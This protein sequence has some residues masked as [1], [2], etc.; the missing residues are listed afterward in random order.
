MIGRSEVGTGPAGED[1]L[2]RDGTIAR[3]RDAAPG[4]R[5]R[6][7]HLHEELSDRHRYERFFHVGDL[8]AARF[9]EG[10]L[11]RLAD[12]EAVA[13]VAVVDGHIAGLASC[14]RAA[15]DGEAELAVVVA[16]RYV[17]RGVATL[18]LEHLAVAASEAGVT[19]LVTYV[20]ADNA[21]AFDVLHHAGFELTSSPH[22][23]TVEVRFPVRLTE[24]VLA[25]MAAREQRADADSIGTLLRP[26]SVAVIGASRRESH[27]GHQVVRNLLRARF[28]GT[29]HPVNPH[30][31]YLLGMRCH[32]SILDVA[33][34][35]L[36]V[37][38]VP[39]AEVPKVV[40][41]CAQGGVRD[42]VILS[43]GFAEAGP[44]GQR[45]Q[46]EVLAIARGSGMRVVG[47]NCLGVA[48]T[49]PD[50]R[51][52]ATFSPMSAGRGRVAM[53]TQ[54]GAVGIAALQ[55]A[56][57]LGVGLSAFI[58]SGNKA[59][60][61]CNDLLMYA[62]E[63]HATDVV[64]LYLES[65]GNPRKFS[66]LAR[67]LGAHKPVVALVGGSSHA[68]R[69]GALGHT[70]SAVTSADAVDALF[71]QCGVIGVHG[72]EQLLQTTSVLANQ[73]LPGGRRVGIVSNAGGPGILAADACASEGL[74]LTT[75]S[76][77]TMAAIREIVPDA[78]SVQMP[79]DL[80]SDVGW[81]AYSE[82]VSTIARSGEIDMLIAL[83]TP[84]PG[85]SYASFTRALRTAL[86]AGSDED[87]PPV[88]TIAV[89][90]DPHGPSR[91]ISAGDHR[92]PVFSFPED[93]ARAL[94]PIARYAEWRAEP[95]TPVS[96][97]PAGSRA[98]AR[99]VV[100]RTLRVAPEGC[101]L[102]EPDA[103]QLLAAYGIGVL[104]SVLA[105]GAEEAVDAA[106]W[107]GYPV[108]VKVADPLAHRTDVGGVR[109]GLRSPDEVR[110][111]AHELLGIAA[112][113]PGLLVQRQVPAGVELI[114]GVT[115][116]KVFGP[117]VMVGYGGVYTELIE[118]RSFL[119]TP[120]CR[121]D[122]AAA[123]ADLRTAPLLTGYRGAPAADAA[124]V[125]HLLVCLGRLA[126]DLPEVAEID[127]NPVIVHERGVSVVDAKV[128]L[129]PAAQAPDPDLR[130]LRP[131]IGP[132]GSD[133]GT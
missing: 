26:R 43:S 66:R 3:V 117:L 61:S 84:L 29:V 70:A 56:E 72:L 120:L 17:H 62:A 15:G 97:A 77:E 90:L 28:T 23:E 55:R 63:D 4:D 33:P 67:R 87:A 65:F 22:R 102:P 6:L 48:N 112:E 9:V 96:E 95:H 52:D 32:S 80:G 47:P 125:E 105:D 41:E 36:A 86:R 24:R 2:L 110:L 53:M 103:R 81:E 18:L 34:V 51:L 119:L 37:L 106:E 107:V 14:T 74:R 31:D 132:G 122:A 133:V 104:P 27:P 11:P 5:D 92:V 64:A 30:C 113:R 130:R 16:D 19:D 111:A 54:S 118:D 25:A 114:A 7:V 35:D 98:T 68:G 21:A 91:P 89:M 8:D 75:L 83:R 129:H 93:A 1:V 115:Q 88:T 59:D 44:E 13:K 45:L 101:R 39:A 69:Q 46:D 38:A 20:M 85:L 131:P 99:E 100:A 57:E 127:L 94:G 121:A 76:A 60:V 126:D 109:L 124:A 128:R 49:D 12:G 71:R 58:S 50:V 79:V 78:S 42:V 116:D 82:V 10:L 73:P 123:I 108:V 40:R